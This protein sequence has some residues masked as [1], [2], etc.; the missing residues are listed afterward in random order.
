[1]PKVK[2]DTERSNKVSE[3]RP[4]LS[5]ERRQRTPR[6]LCLSSSALKPRPSPTESLRDVSLSF[7]ERRRTLRVPSCSEWLDDLRKED[8]G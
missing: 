7:L 8:P 6:R 3:D 5:S 2:E 4:N 1:M